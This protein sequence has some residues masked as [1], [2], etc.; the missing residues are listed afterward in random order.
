MDATYTGLADFAATWREDRP[1]D[2]PFALPGSNAPLPEHAEA[3]VRRH[4]EDVL[5]T[6]VALQRGEWLQ[7]GVYVGPRAMSPVY[8]AVLE[9]SKSLGVAIPPA[10]ISGC[11]PSLQGTF[12]T[13]DRP[14]LRLSTFFMEKAAPQERLFLSGRLCG[15]IAAGQVTWITLYALLVDHNGL[16]RVARRNLG[17]TLEGRPRPPVPRGTPRPQPMAPSRRGE[18]GPGGV[19]GGARPRRRRS[20]PAARRTGNETRPLT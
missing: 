20:L 9:A 10:I 15:H 8:E 11:S 7:D 5:D 17:P 13:D 12:G 16:R 19:A 1:A 6:V 18:R 2:A 3:H 4:L 14:F